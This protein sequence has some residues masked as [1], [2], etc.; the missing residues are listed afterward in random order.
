MAEDRIQISQLPSTLSLNES[1]ELAIN[2]A[3]DTRKASLTQ[4]K[5]TIGV[6]DH[7]ADLEAHR[8]MDDT[9]TAPDTIWS[10]QKTRDEID[11]ALT[12]RQVNS[13][14]FSGVLPPT[15]GGTGMGTLDGG[16]LL[17]TQPDAM[18]EVAMGPTLAETGGAIDVVEDTSV[19]KVELAVD[20]N[21]GGVRKQV[22]FISNGD[23]VVELSDDPIN[24]KLDAEI[25]L[26]ARGPLEVHD[27]GIAL[28]GT[29]GIVNIV[30]GDNVRTDLVFNAGDPEGEPAIPS[31][32]EVTIH[33]DVSIQD[34]GVDIATRPKLNFKDGLNTVA[35]VTDDPVN[36][37]IDVNVDVDLS[38]KANVTHT[39]TL[40]EVGDAGL[41]ASKDQV[42][43]PTDFS[44]TGTPDATTF[45]RGDNVWAIPPGGTG[46]VDVYDNGVLTGSRGGVNFIAGPNVT[47]TQS[48][49]AG[50]DK[51]DVT[52]E[53]T[54]SGGGGG[55]LWR[56]SSDVNVANTTSLTQ[57]F[58]YTIPGGTLGPGDVIRVHVRGS[59]LNNT[60]GLQ[61]FS[62]RT[63]LGGQNQDSAFSN[64][65]N[66]AS[67]FDWVL[68]YEI[69][70]NGSGSQ[71]VTAHL[72]T[73][74]HKADPEDEGWL[75]TTNLNLDMTVDQTFQLFVT[76]FTANASL[77]ITKEAAWVEH[78]A[79]SD[80]GGG[81]GGGGGITGVG[82][83]NNSATIVGTRP[84]I[85]FHPGSNVTLT[86]TD[87]AV[88][89]EVDVTIAAATGSGSSM[90]L[91]VQ[92]YGAVGDGVTSDSSA[93]QAAINDSVTLG[94]SGVFFPDGVYRIT[95]AITPPGGSAG[96]ERPSI[97]NW[98][99]ISERIT[100][101]KDPGLQNGDPIAFQGDGLPWTVTENK[102]FNAR[103]ISA[104]EYELYDTRS[105]ATNTAST[106]GRIDLIGR[107]VSS[108][109]LTTNEITFSAPHL[110]RTGQR[111]RFQSTGSLPSGTDINTEYVFRV[112]SPTVG[113]IHPIN[114]FTTSNDF[115]AYHAYY[116]P[117]SQPSGGR[118]PEII[119]IT[120][121]GSGTID[122]KRV[123]AQLHPGT[124]KYHNGLIL[125][126]SGN[127]IIAKDPNQ[128]LSLLF[129]A[130]RF[131]NLVVED[132]EFWGRNY[133]ERWLDEFGGSYPYWGD[134]GFRV[135]SCHNVV[136][137][138]CRFKYFGD[139]A[140][141]FQTAFNDKNIGPMAESLTVENCWFFMCTQT[142]STVS[143]TAHP[144]AATTIRFINNTFEKMRTGVK[145]S[146]KKTEG[147]ADAWFIGN[148]WKDCKISHQF[149]APLEIQSFSR[150]Y[151]K[152]NTWENQGTT[153]NIEPYCILI[154]PNNSATASKGPINNITLE[155][156][157]IENCP[158]GFKISNRSYID[159]P[160]VMED[161]T[162]RGNHF[163]NLTSTFSE[164]AI[165]I[166]INPVRRV[167]ISGN[168]FD[169]IANQYCI[170][171]NL[172]DDSD[173]VQSCNYV[174]DSNF[175]GNMT[176][177]SASL[178]SL[179]LDNQG[180]PVGAKMLRGF[181]FSNSVITTPVPLLRAIN[182]SDMLF[183]NIIYNAP[184][185][186]FHNPTLF[187]GI[188]RFRYNNC[189]I[190]AT[191]G[192]DHPSTPHLFITGCSFNC[193]GIAIK[194]AT[195]QSATAFIEGNHV[196]SGSVSFQ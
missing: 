178:I 91:N 179:T 49:D 148:K 39:H 155:G 123:G 187:S 184:S 38:G 73:F 113:T 176:H 98:N 95:T 45:L 105:N 94:L 109:N 23:V 164:G 12:N 20:G 92:D 156:N 88:N 115:P 134:D 85:N 174:L 13:D 143:N 111:V 182:V 144:S 107:T 6:T 163:R 112:V 37:R 152:D 60:G 16:K 24:N 46:V 175:F 159:G 131:D 75:L 142:S 145:L 90:F 7:L 14:Q 87:D 169:D 51:V 141:R 108:I 52:I 166:S 137:N 146:S 125:K 55:I 196:V 97:V 140:L 5:K 122:M 100:F 191:N 183:S 26:L 79:E 34:E 67:G 10:S 84:N 114:N 86:I 43:A 53:A 172:I 33:A 129:W 8:P 135:E 154:I 104:L 173:G 195:S 165:S 188:S 74:Q 35:V 162:I 189:H 22:N 153:G 121:A 65:G 57:L 47:I 2:N 127:A 25:K 3:G 19:Q 133:E 124:T 194:N 193:S 132:L 120:S 130:H 93:I 28:A 21:L 161:V 118:T 110:M 70:A 64:F 151:V 128:G 68:D 27:N 18:T 9:V 138:R 31:S 139:G 177:A 77:S 80:S 181:I 158:R 89:N 167:E 171:I 117:S 58:S 69:M 126:G 78:V 62:W 30:E 157:V 150:V 168:H 29:V 136:F 170:F 81:G 54:G 66:H 40:S 83:R 186:T 180:G 56:D 99:P 147:I 72:Q 17:I 71:Q 61:A 185:G 119:D 4:V 106:A 116:Y 101:D 48:D 63:S 102:V 42:E 41:L 76:P 190:T 44:A 59:G 96:R 160:V 15:K 32:V 1:D 82:I 192:I 103:R 36:S 50:G 149:N 11:T